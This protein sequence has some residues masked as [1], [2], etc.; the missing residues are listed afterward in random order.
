MYSSQ[1]FIIR[2]FFSN[3][4]SDLI[5]KLFLFQQEI[6]KVENIVTLCLSHLRDKSGWKQ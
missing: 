6:L 2:D 1:I 3:I 5:H 4:F